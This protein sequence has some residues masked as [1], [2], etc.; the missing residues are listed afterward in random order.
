MAALETGLLP[1]L[2]RFAEEPHLAAVRQ[3]IV[4]SFSALIAVTIIAFFTSTPQHRAADLWEHALRRFF[5]AYHIGFGA[6]GVLLALLLGY[7]LGRAFKCS[8]VAGAVFA[9]GAFFAALPWPQ[10]H[11]IGLALGIL[12]S[13]SIFLALVVALVTGEVLRWTCIYVTSRA[14]A[15]GIAAAG[16]AALFGVLAALHVSVAALLT[17]AIKPLVSVGDTL[18]AL[19]LVVFLQ[20]LLWTAGVHGP[21]FLS[22]VVTPVYLRAIDENSQALL[23]HQT[24]PHIVTIMI[25]AFLFPGGSGA[26]LPL[27][28]LL[29]RSKVERLRKL[30]YAAIFPSL[31]NVNE[32]LIFGLPLVMNPSLILPFIG[33][34]LI[35]AT[36]TYGCIRFGLVHKSVVWLPSAVPSFVAGWLTTKGDLRAVLLVIVNVAIGLVLYYPFLR[37]FENGLRGAAQPPAESSGALRAQRVK[38][39]E[40]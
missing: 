10:P 37:S 35:L 16:C 34:P 20:T 31:A 33:V 30:G 3:A 19:L 27:S 26:T 22:A 36:L 15:L 6:M 32:P 9:L 8:P 28:I 25:F 12:S 14:L 29:L 11:S 23:A 39:R 38:A 1:R 4:P 2:R 17:D 13:T 24:P 21:A 18:P 7:R 40:D 5:D